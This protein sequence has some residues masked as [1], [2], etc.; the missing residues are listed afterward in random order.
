LLRDIGER[1]RSVSQADQSSDPPSA[2]SETERLAQLVAGIVAV[3][4]IRHDLP[5]RPGQIVICR[6]PGAAGTRVMRRDISR[7]W[8]S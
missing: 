6:N 8:S 3:D 5:Y 7:R 2:A 4:E 1:E